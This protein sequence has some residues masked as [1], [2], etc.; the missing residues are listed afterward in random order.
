MEKNFFLSVCE[1]KAVSALMF[2]PVDSP[3]DDDAVSNITKSCRFLFIFTLESNAIEFLG[4]RNRDKVT[5]LM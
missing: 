1:P 2:H 4:T 5:C 3:H